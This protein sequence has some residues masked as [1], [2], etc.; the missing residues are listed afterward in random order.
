M[1]SSSV[2]KNKCLRQVVESVGKDKLSLSFSF[3]TFVSL[4]DYYTHVRPQK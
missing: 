2:E 1:S 4:Y 3:R